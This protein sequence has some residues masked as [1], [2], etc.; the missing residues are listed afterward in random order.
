MKVPQTYHNIT[1]CSLNISE[2]YIVNTP[3]DV[4]EMYDFTKKRLNKV[5]VNEKI[6]FYDAI[7]AEPGCPNVISLNT[8][9]NKLSVINGEHNS[10]ISIDKY[11]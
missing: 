7:T 4:N 5:I 9:A 10:S 2:S 8:Y 11:L 6:R 1:L 3:L